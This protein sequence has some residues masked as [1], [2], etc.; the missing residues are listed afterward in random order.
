MKLAEMM[1]VSRQAVSKWEVG[2]AVPSTDN[3]K[4]LGQLYGVSLEYLLQDDALEPNADPEKIASDN[5]AA[6]RKSLWIALTIMLLLSC[7][8]FSLL[9]R[10]RP[11]A[12]DAACK[13]VSVQVYSPLDGIL[14]ALHED[15]YNEKRSWGFLTATASGAPF[16][17]IGALCLPRWGFASSFSM[18]GGGCGT[19]PWKARL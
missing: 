6:K 12:S 18:T 3:L 14:T 16:S 13:V 4:Y 9:Y 5:T 8:S 2:S 17:R 11:V 7:V 19:P 1:N 15:S 10:T